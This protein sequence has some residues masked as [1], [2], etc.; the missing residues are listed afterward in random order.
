MNNQKKSLTW[1]C[2]P[3]NTSSKGVR[4]MSIK[5]INP[6][7]EQVLATYPFMTPKK[8]EDGI[9]KGHQAWLQWRKTD[10]AYRRE[11]MQKIAQ[12]LRQKQENL[13]RLI[14]A[15]MGK[16]LAASIS[17]IQKCAWVCEHYASEAEHYLAPTEIKTDKQKSTIYY[18]PTGVV[19][20]IMPWNFPFWQVFR[21]AAPTLMAGNTG[22]LKHAPVSTG[23]GNTIAE[24]FVEAGFPE[25][26]FQHF[27]LD[28]DLAAKVIAHEHIVAVTLT[29]SERAGSAVAA[30]A[31]RH[32]KKAVLE[33]GG[34]DPYIILEDADLDQAAR[35]IVTSRL[36]NTGQV[37]IAAKRI[38]AVKTIHDVLVKKV[39][40]LTQRAVMGDP[41]N[42]NTTMGPMARK[43]LRETLQQQVD[44][45]IAKGAHLVSGGKIPA[46]TGY[47]YPPTVL[48]NVSPGMPAFDDEL[49]GPVI[50]FIQARDEKDAIK[51]ANQSR[52]G[53]GGGVFTKDLERG[54][55]IAREDIDV[56]SCFVNG[57]VSSDPRLPFGGIKHS[58]FG[59]E[60]AR[61]GILAFVNVKTV[62][63]N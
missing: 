48:T 57:F 26:V 47:Y 10:F 31:G 34:N 5:T 25:G 30:H 4:N 14:T 50:T 16:P 51:L 36:N 35:C 7:T 18:L 61:E 54:E 62:A 27:V 6:A 11:R 46:G 13:G 45:S 59:R 44:E 20:A 58:G 22:I 28:N 42:P 33:L 19:F 24:L 53:L 23:T 32:L 55:R 63:V 43:D 38:I 39:M 3:P 56:G 29:G 9:E 21:F 2:Y 40:K 41:L 17:E 49:F 1:L 15:E 60:L 37:C 8:I 52:F 12:L